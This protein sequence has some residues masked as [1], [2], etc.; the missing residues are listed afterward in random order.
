MRHAGGLSPEL[1]SKIEEVAT[2]ARSEP[3]KKPGP[4]PKGVVIDRA[5]LEA[6]GGFLEPKKSRAKK[7]K[8][9]KKPKAPKPEGKPKASMTDGKFLKVLDDLAVFVKTGRW[10]D[11]RPIH[12]V[13]LYA[14]LHF[15]VYGVEPFDLDA[16]TRVFAA[17]LAGSLLARKFSG[18]KAEF[19]KFMAWTWT[20][21]KEREQYSKESGKTRN[22]RVG[23]QL[24]FGPRFLTDYLVEQGRRTVK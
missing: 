20:R 5:A 2:V 6:P 11:A 7:P 14:D 17:G 4:K 23:W 24:Q 12:F 15:R 9:E 22:T 8:K 10:D 16:T 13:A 1:Q 18:N 21:E 3:K 19:Q